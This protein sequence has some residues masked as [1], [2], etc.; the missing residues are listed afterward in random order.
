MSEEKIIPVQKASKETLDRLQN[1]CVEAM[2][3][4]L[5]DLIVEEL[6][7]AAGGESLYKRA[8]GMPLPQRRAT[9]PRF[10]INSEESDGDDDMITIDMKKSEKGFILQV[11]DTTYPAN[12]EGLLSAAVRYQVED[13]LLSDEYIPA[14]HPV[15]GTL[16][17]MVEGYGPLPTEKGRWVLESITRNL[18]R[19]IV[20]ALLKTPGRTKEGMVMVKDFV[21]ESGLKQPGIMDYRQTACVRSV[22]PNTEGKTEAERDDIYENS[23]IN[24]AYELLAGNMDRIE[25]DSERRKSQL[26]ALE[27][28]RKIEKT[29][30]PEYA[31]ILRRAAESGEISLPAEDASRLEKTFYKVL[32]EVREQMHEIIEDK[33][34]PFYIGMVVWDGKDE[35]GLPELTFDP[36]KKVFL[37]PAR[38]AE[39]NQLII[40]IPAIEGGTL[41]PEEMRKNAAEIVD[42][43]I[44][45]AILPHLAGQQHPLLK[46]CYFENPEKKGQ[47]LL[48]E[49]GAEYLHS[50]IDEMAGHAAITAVQMRILAPEQMSGFRFRMHYITTESDAIHILPQ[51]FNL[52]YC[53]EMRNARTSFPVPGLKPRAA[54]AD[55]ELSEL[56]QMMHQKGLS[57][58]EMMAE[59]VRRAQGHTGYENLKLLGDSIYKVLEQALAEGPEKAGITPQMLRDTWRE[60]QYNALMQLGRDVIIRMLETNMRGTEHIKDPRVPRIPRHPAYDSYFTKDQSGNC[61]LT[62]TGENVLGKLVKDSSARL[63]T[64]LMKQGQS[65]RGYGCQMTYSVTNKGAISY[66]LKQIPIEMLTAYARLLQANK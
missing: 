53:V 4:Y 1:S 52:E 21:D 62:E 38:P 30:N 3:D 29:E 20:N 19:D 23:A 47:Y 10:S 24:I 18:T 26:D 49:K 11:P 58:D 16:I 32:D 8:T 41:T 56:V 66:E 40:N 34:F 25:P 65:E 46:A 37:D 61:A 33:E 39:K 14:E 13:A 28:L 27:H 42:K 51:G 50:T 2:N 60:N 22:M 63:A 55:R 44:S 6:N 57:K 35:K 17:E 5:R 54:D 31:D 15:H 48:S 64:D 9:Q 43:V 12:L 59:T 7:S 36:A 45:Y